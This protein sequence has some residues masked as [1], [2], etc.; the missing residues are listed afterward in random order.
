[1]TMR[2]SVPDREKAD[3]H[4]ASAAIL[5][6]LSAMAIAAMPPASPALATQNNMIDLNAGDRTWREEFDAICGGVETATQLSIEDLER[7]LFRCR[8]L[9]PRIETLPGTLRK[10]FGRRLGMCRDLYRFV[11]DSRSNRDEVHG[12]GAVDAGREREQTN[13]RDQQKN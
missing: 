11:L 8:V 4:A 12:E 6:L 9:E 13:E 3:R 7:I 2:A 1:M 5:I 10:V